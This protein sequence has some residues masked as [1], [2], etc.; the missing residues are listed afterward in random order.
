[1]GVLTDETLTDNLADL[2]GTSRD[3]AARILQS[4]VG[5][6]KDGLLE[7]HQLNIEGFLSLQVVQEKARIV[8]MPDAPSRLIE[9][10]RNTLVT[11]ALPTFEQELAE[12]RLTPILLVVPADDV[13][14]EIVTYHFRQAGWR[15]E[16]AHDP[17]AVAESLRDGGLLV[18]VDISLPG[19]QELLERLKTCPAT[20]SVPTI[21]LFPRGGRPGRPSA[22][23]LQADQELVEPFEL[24]ELLA[25]A[26]RELVRSAE[27]DLLFDQQVQFV[28][29]STQVDLD[30]ATDLTREL[31]ATSGLGEAEQTAFHAAVREA[32]GNAVQHG[33]RFEPERICRVQYLVDPKRV[34]VIVR[35]EGDG[36]D[37]RR[38]V[39]HASRDAV[40]AAR[41]RYAQGRRGGLGILMMTR[42]ADRIEYN[43]KGTVVTLTKFLQP[44]ARPGTAGDAGQHAAHEVED[45]E[46]DE[47]LYL[48]A[49]DDDLR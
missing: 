17:D 46:I 9:P 47:D 33:G 21:A 1:M 29:P 44:P 27:E 22:L 41:H 49:L 26:E 3:E 15:V 25:F 5:L 39:H 45:I 14:A 43:D 20:N 18:I 34:T 10:P 19:G 2:L 7:G 36:F 4:T 8:Q 48:Q 37:H 42:A 35:D 28:L 31:L 38:Y 6:L 30:R 40:Q 12:V 24:A 23:R 11:T 16:V 32:I 13:F